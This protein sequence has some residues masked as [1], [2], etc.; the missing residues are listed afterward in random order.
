MALEFN[1]DGTPIVKFDQR[2][3]L[4]IPYHDPSNDTHPYIFHGKHY[5]DGEAILTKT[6]EMNDA[7]LPFVLFNHNV[8]HLVYDKRVIRILEFFSI[9][10]VNHF[11]TTYCTNER[12][13]YW[14][15]MTKV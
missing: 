1:E 9:I 6:I 5:F 15:L 8:Y 13:N 14:K 7:K 4:I 3:S 11:F 12:Y 10:E 2:I